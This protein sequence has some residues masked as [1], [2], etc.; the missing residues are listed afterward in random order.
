M[1]EIMKC[2]R[3]KIIIQ[4]KEFSG[5]E[6]CS[7]EYEDSE[8]IHLCGNCCNLYSMLQATI[9]DEFL[10]NRINLSRSGKIYLQ[11]ERLSEKTS[12]DDAI[13]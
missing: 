10:D 4:D 13:V 12:K 11:P 1:I 2:W 8:G 7:D 9:Y 3:C 5:C 6:D